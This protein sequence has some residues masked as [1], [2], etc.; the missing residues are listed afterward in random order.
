MP[1]WSKLNHALLSSEQDSSLMIG[2]VRGFEEEATG[3]L[4][5]LRR[6]FAQKSSASEVTA[7]MS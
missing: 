5:T 2:Q 1:F 7:Q 6:A 4:A 3:S